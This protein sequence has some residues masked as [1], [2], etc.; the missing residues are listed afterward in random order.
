MS[1]IDIG[2]TNNGDPIGFIG[3]RIRHVPEMNLESGKVIILRLI[4]YVLYLWFLP[5]VWQQ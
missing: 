4:D 5:K 1:E 3:N 2:V